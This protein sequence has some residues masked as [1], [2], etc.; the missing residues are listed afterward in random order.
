MSGATASD[1]NRSKLTVPLDFLSEIANADSLG[2]LYDSIAKWMPDIFPADRISIALP[3]DEK[4]LAVA[5]VRGDRIRYD[6]APIPIDGSKLGDCYV[7][8]NPIVV[9]DADRPGERYTRTATPGQDR[10]R[11]TAILPLVVGDSCLGTLN[12]GCVAANSFPKETVVDLGRIATWIAL[13][14]NRFETHERLKTSEARFNALIENAQ[15]MIFAKAPDGTMLI[16]NRKYCETHG[17]QPDDVIGRRDAEIF[18]DAQA[19]QW[20]QDENRILRSGS[21]K[22]VEEELVHADG[23]TRTHMTQKFAVFDPGRGEHIICAISTDISDRKEVEAAL[24]ESESRARAFFDNSPSLMFMKDRNHRIS[25]ANRGFLEFYK[26][27]EEQVLGRQ[28]AAYVPPDLLERFEA[29]DRN[30]I[31][32]SV[33]SQT[34]LQFPD[35]EGNMHDFLTIKF[36]ANGADGNPVGLGGINIE[37]TELRSRERELEIARDEAELAALNFEQAADKARAAD[38]AKTDFLASMSHELRTPLNGIL[39]MTHLL[40]MEDLTAEQQNK[41]DTIQES[42]DALLIL[43]NDILDLSKVEAGELEVE[44]REFRLQDLVASIE[45]L[46]E[47]QAQSKQ[48]G[49]RCDVD[50]S[51]APVLIGDD[52]KLRQIVFNLV[53]NALKFTDDG[54][55]GLRVTQ[56]ESPDGRVMNRFEVSDTGPGIPHEHQS[57]LFD[58]FTQADS[59]ISRRY[60]GTGLGLAICKSLIELMGGEIGYDTAPREGTTFWITLACEP[61]TDSALPAPDAPDAPDAPETPAKAVPDQPLTIL[62]AEDNSVNQQIIRLMLEKAGHRCDMAENGAQ[63]VEAVRRQDYDLVLMDIQMPEMDGIAATSAIRSLGGKR[64]KTPIVALTANAMKGDRALYLSAGMNDY[65]AKPIDPAALG[66]ALSR[67]TGSGGTIEAFG[68][69]GIVSSSAPV[70]PD[71]SLALEIDAL[72]DGL[73]FA[74]K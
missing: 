17:L 57:R 34:E 8:R 54:E 27:T 40:A 44:I 24:A 4:F 32:N 15:A 31:E 6:V 74:D 28:S 67:Q 42:G 48:L 20:Q 72:F 68:D 16:A 47:P 29:E 18:G 43:L 62:V 35:A 10:Y 45:A 1:R 39:G 63:A 12:L 58:K 30:I 22:T 7:S 14:L 61:G 56:S 23:V 65:V 38:R 70:E 71:P 53:S 60:G 41:V 66:A 5:A 55:I 21:G 51:V 25:F 2:V 59:T 19:K 36:P 50:L 64:A 37:T 69:R 49:W 33:V 52:A 26:T 13:Q 3:K 11:S 9:N 73:D 46:W